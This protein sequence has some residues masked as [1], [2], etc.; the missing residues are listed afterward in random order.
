MTRAKRK[1]RAAKA[2]R[3]LILCAVETNSIYNNIYKTGT[4]TIKL[5]KVSLVRSG[6]DMNELKDKI[7][8]I[9]DVF[10]FDVKFKETVGN[11]WGGPAFI[12]KL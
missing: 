7:S 8:L 9:A 4:R 3:E 2:I 12:V 10:D 11:R 5:Y 1:L 6:V